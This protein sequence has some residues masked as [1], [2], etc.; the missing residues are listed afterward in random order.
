MKEIKIIKKHD[1]LRPGAVINVTDMTAEKRVREGLAEFVQLKE[2]KVEQET[3]EE[4]ADFETKE[5]K[6][7]GRKTKAPK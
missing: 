1:G 5:E 4:K 2:E 3:K 7:K 6:P